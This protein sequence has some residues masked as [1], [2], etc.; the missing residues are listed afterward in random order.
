MLLRLFW[1]F[2]LALTLFST[3]GYGQSVPNPTDTSYV[4]AL[5]KKG[6]AIE[7]RQ[8][9]NAL[10]FYQ[11]AHDFSKKINY[12]K[13]YFESV[14]LMVY[15]LNNL[16]QHDKARKLAQDALLRAKQD[17]SKRNLGISYFAL[18]NTALFSGKLTEAIPNYQQAAYY[19]RLIGKLKNVAVINQNLGYI[20]EQQR[21]LPQALAHYKKALAFDSTD[22]QDRRSIA[23]DYFSIANLL[24]KQ[25]KIAES[26][27]MYLKAKQ[28]VDP[29]N[30]LDFMINLYNNIGYQYGV[31]AR[32][33]S[34]LFYQ[35]E[36][37]QFSRQLGNPRHELHMLMALAQTSS[38]MKNYAQARTLL[39]ESHRIAQK[40]KVG[41]AEF[42]NIYRE[43][44][45]ATEGLHDY[46]ATTA[47]LDKYIGVRDSLNN[48]ET[49]ELLESYE[50]QL[51]QAEARQKLAEKQR[52]IDHL[53]EERQRQNLWLLIAGLIGL[54][55][56]GG[57]V[58]ASLYS[59]QRQRTADTALV[60]A[61]RERE[62]AVVQS[63]LQGQQ[64]ER[65]RIS[66]E[67]HDDLGASL[68]AIG[69][70][71]EVVKS[72]M[73]TNTTPEI[74]KISTISADMVTAMNE[75]IWSL[76]TRNDSLN[77]LIAYTRAY[78][79]EFIDNTDLRLKTDVQESAHEIAMRGADRRNVFL[80]VK[81]ALNNV[82]KHAGATQ[83]TL[84][85]R[86]ETD[87]LVIE[88]NDN[89]HGF[90]PNEK[91][92]LR[93]GLG[94]M[95]NRM[96]ESGGNCEIVSSST[97]TSVRITYPYPPVAADKILQT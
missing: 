47:W 23:I 78:A 63:E 33:D 44:A 54:V 75:I 18:A 77:G 58:F 50:L 40:N 61:Q 28:W 5:L 83:I 55:A 35:R 65:L 12:T 90:T 10:N 52:Q 59:R 25:D 81:E 49:K 8:T 38:R 34:A 76:N 3:R 17:T 26:N 45:V 66:K 67:M 56:M 42:G 15:L 31:E 21:M 91:T 89:G 20:Y 94:N 6:E 73:G 4:M 30:D 46:K 86:P 93:N 92:S 41:L 79:S 82:V 36:A 64:K 7:T 51:K 24:S 13:G 43:Y 9:T 57:L 84:L 27:A 29:K 80:T 69:L 72:R 53:E 85:I 16:G 11:K 71:S 97:G 96:N 48:Q 32:Y 70:L 39:D 60:A 95:Q 2:L 14:R 68:T 1:N 19:M 88:V 22:K 37:L 74:E 87:R 62:L